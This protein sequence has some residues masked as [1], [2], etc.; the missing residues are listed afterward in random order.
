MN[1]ALEGSSIEPKHPSCPRCKYDLIGLTVPVRC[2]ECG[3]KEVEFPTWLRSSPR[4]P[5]LKMCL[6]LI[7]ACIDCFIWYFSIESIPDFFRAPFAPSI[8]PFN[9][10]PGAIA[11]LS[12]FFVQLPLTGVALLIAFVGAASTRDRVPFLVGGI[13]AVAGTGVI[14]ILSISAGL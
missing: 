3:L 14:W 9:P 2:P 11:Y 7:L 6:L 1:G 12:M 13:V 10:K 5:I 4:F 8:V